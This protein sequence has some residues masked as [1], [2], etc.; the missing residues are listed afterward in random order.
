MEAKAKTHAT[1]TKEEWMAK[2]QELFGPQ[3]FDWRFRCPSCGNVQSAEDFRSYQSKGATADSAR[4]ECIGRYDGHI[5]VEI[6][7]TPGPCNYTSGGLFNLNPVT[8]VD[9]DR[10]YSSFAFDLDAGLH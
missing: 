6:G 1:M 7:T 8:V 4:S 9:G 5:V 3:M 10:R 2:G